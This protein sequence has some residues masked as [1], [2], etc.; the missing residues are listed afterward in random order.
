MCYD[1]FRS[2]NFQGVSDCFRWTLHWTLLSW[3][4]TLNPIWSHHTPVCPKLSIYVWKNLKKTPREYLSCQFPN[5]SIF[6]G[7]R[8]S[9]NFCSEPKP[10]SSKDA[11]DPNVE[12]SHR[13]HP[14]ALRCH[15]GPG[16][17]GTGAGNLW[18]Q[19]EESRG[20]ETAKMW[21]KAED[22]GLH[23]LLSGWSLSLSL[24][25]CLYIYIY[26]YYTHNNYV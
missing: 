22:E 26:T 15:V 19:E 11:A 21:S 9:S 14:K 7:W 6:W 17:H 5:F 1:V 12:R 16:R 23:H 8:G 2:I 24:S 4:A 20:A 18:D 25:L 10:S 3:F 13:L